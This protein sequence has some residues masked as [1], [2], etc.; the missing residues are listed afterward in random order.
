MKKKI[1]AL[2]LTII[3]VISLLPT[4]VFAN[5]VEE[6]E[7]NVITENGT[8]QVIRKKLSPTT[9]HVDLI[10]TPADGYNLTGIRAV[11]TEGSAEISIIDFNGL[12]FDIQSGMLKENENINI[13]ATF[14]KFN[15]DKT[16]EVTWNGNGS[17]QNRSQTPAT[18][19]ENKLSFTFEANTTIPRELEFF[20][21][22]EEN[23]SI[24]VSSTNIS[25]NQQGF[26]LKVQ[27]S[28]DNLNTYDSFSVQVDFNK[29]TEA[30]QEIIDEKFNEVTNDGKIEVNSIPISNDNIINGILIYQWTDGGNKNG[31]E[32]IEFVGRNMIS[33]EVEDN[34]YFKKVELAFKNPDQKILDKVKK[35]EQKIL[36]GTKKI[37]N[38]NAYEVSDMEML[39]YLLSKPNKTTYYNG[40]FINGASLIK[41]SGD[42]AKVTDSDNI[43]VE[44]LMESGGGN[45][46]ITDSYGMTFISYDGVVYT[47]FGTTPNDI[48]GA[49]G[50]NIIYVPNGTDKNINSYIEAA[51]IRINDYLGVEATITPQGIISNNQ[52]MMDIIGSATMCDQ[53]YEVKI[54]DKSFLFLIIADSS[55]IKKP[56]LIT[57]DIKSGSLISTEASEVPLDSTISISELDKLNKKEILSKIGLTDGETY[58]IY[59]HSNSKGGN[60]KQ[61][62]NGLFE[63][64]IPIKDIKDTKNLKAYY[65]KD[66]GTLEIHDVEV[67]GGVAY[68]TTDHFS[69]YTIG[70]ANDTPKTGDNNLATLFIVLAMLSLMGVV[71]VVKKIVIK[72]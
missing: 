14:S 41:Y 11:P 17:V 38:L 22:P 10:A 35:L 47:A 46:F 6:H 65:V 27:F 20:L 9:E 67:R 55:K 48:V 16:L 21:T 72:R 4:L 3:M 42:F 26:K 66:D 53:Y 30:Q 36:D 71:L 51:K 60:I 57:K 62:S 2:V 68:F 15:V 52:D 69:T 54:G 5:P 70:I 24:S 56:G 39:N 44:L 63:V 64:G 61:L 33:I 49:R 13:Y 18:L 43:E 31:F 23:N 12:S 37:G 32:G 34:K 8:I 59:L 25:T 19:H 28:I 1:L 7:I 45:P 29:A 40:F 50:Y 58:D